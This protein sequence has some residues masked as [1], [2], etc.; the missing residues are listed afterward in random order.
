M[1]SEPSN[2][3]DT[4]E[5]DQMIKTW[6]A[7]HMQRII[8]MR[9]QPAEDLGISC[10]RWVDSLRLIGIIITVASVHIVD[11]MV[12]GLLTA[13]DGIMEVTPRVGLTPP[14]WVRLL[15]VAERVWTGESP[16]VESGWVRAVSGSWCRM[17]IED[18]QEML[19]S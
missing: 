12:I 15:G 9:H 17:V 8:A 1:M 7:Q 11:N 18:P 10:A 6:L 4:I 5:L 14:L 13:H 2:E 3:T 16:S 19:E